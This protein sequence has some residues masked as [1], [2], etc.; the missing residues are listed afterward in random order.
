[1]QRHT[2]DYEVEEPLYQA[3]L[4]VL[5][6]YQS[7]SAELLRLALFLLT[8]YGFLLKEIVLPGGSPSI[9]FRKLSERPWLLVGSL[10]AIGICAAASLVHRYASTDGF[11]SLVAYHRGSKRLAETPSGETFEVMERTLTKEYRTMLL[12]FKVS[13]WSLRL[14]A[15]A[16]GMAAAGT[17]LAFI[18][19]LTD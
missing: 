3:D 7:Y 9:F 11:R 15:L 14:S 8:G 5:S 16:L 6:K 18:F 10:I 19:T 1:M 17:S 2:L 4:E 12:L 13:T